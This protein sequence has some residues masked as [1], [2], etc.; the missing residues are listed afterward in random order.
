MSCRIAAEPQPLQVLHNINF[1]YRRRTAL[2]IV[3]E[4]GAGKSMLIKAIMGIA[5]SSVS[6]QGRITLDGHDLSEHEA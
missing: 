4:S 5:P 1:R 2:G 3:G 6:I